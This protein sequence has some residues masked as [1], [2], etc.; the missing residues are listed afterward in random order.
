MQETINNL[1]SEKFCR[2]LEGEKH[3]EEKKSKGQSGGLVS[4]SRGIGVIGWSRYHLL[5]HL[6]EVREWR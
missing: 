3:Y 5:T 2:I 4:L 1:I 6:K